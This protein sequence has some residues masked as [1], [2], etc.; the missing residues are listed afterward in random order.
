MQN[1]YS[2]VFMD[3]LK[4]A[5]YTHCFYVSGGNVMHL[6][7]SA[8]YRFKCI[9]FIH[10]ATACIATDYFNEVSQNG[11]KAFLLV[12]AGPGITNSITGIA[13]AW[14]D[15]R[16]LLIIGGQV[17]TKYLAK[18][19]T[20]QIGFQEIDGVELCKSI[21]KETIRIEKQI[22][23]DEVFRLIALSK[24]P[25]KGPVFIEFCL[26]ISMEKFEITKEP[27][28]VITDK[29]FDGPEVIDNAINEVLQLFYN[30]KRPLILLGGGVDRGTNLV[31]LKRHNLPVATTFNGADRIN[32]DYQF[33][34]GMPNWYGSRWANLI[35]QQADLILA[36]GTSLGVMQTGYNFEEFAPN[37]KVIKV[38]VDINEL[39]KG[40]IEIYKGIQLDCN[41]FIKQF[42]KLFDKKH[43]PIYDKWRD[44]VKEI[45]KVLS[46]PEKINTARPPYIQSIDFLLQLCRTMDGKEI[47]IPC[48]SGAA[49]YE[50]AMRTL[51]FKGENLVVTSHAMASMG[52][53]LAG[54]IGA[55]IAHPEKKVIVI[56]GDGGFAQ[57][58]QEVS[59]AIKNNLNLKLFI[60]DNG[61]Y[62]SIRGNQRS[63]FNDHYI[64]CDENSGLL[65]PK[66]HQI[67]N[68]FGCKVF[69]VDASTAFNEI[70]NELFSS[71]GFVI[72][73][74]KIDPDQTYYPRVL[75]KRNSNGEVISNPLHTM[76]PPLDQKTEQEFSKFI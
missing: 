9:P 23:K 74:V 75:S 65:L 52:F 22:G 58:L 51:E 67:G 48:S 53:G 50:S 30:S 33:Y 27:N 34:C 54:G 39:T 40:T 60:M 45:R 38:D 32:H 69:E 57:N 18:G 73:I 61:G 72:F 49:A 63:A 68:F 70:F 12:T 13:S 16:E 35:L 43:E 42:S 2:D 19:R 10:E 37:A 31:E 3:W 7:E 28:K 46:R 8:S 26:D 5:G 36:L 25:R 59:T 4:E 15:S 71:S 17:S 21:T 24:T 1:K 66:W 41:L 20:R 14:M 62:Q 64:G 6:L 11:S 47:I 29:R 44:Y 55:S 56:E 76:H